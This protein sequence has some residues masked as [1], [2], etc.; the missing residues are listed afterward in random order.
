MS[1]CFF[2]EGRLFFAGLPP[3]VKGS[4]VG[5]RRMLESQME[6]NW[7]QN[8]RAFNLMKERV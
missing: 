6:A 7:T 3:L 5:R 1:K 2:W 8:A 4:M